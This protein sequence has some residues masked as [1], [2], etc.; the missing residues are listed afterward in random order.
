MVMACLTGFEVQA[1]PWKDWTT[2]R[3]WLRRLMP[4]VPW[5]AGLTWAC[6]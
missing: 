5:S 6:K 4:D 1:F 3:S 2:G